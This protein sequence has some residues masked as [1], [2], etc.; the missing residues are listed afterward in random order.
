MIMRLEKKEVQD[1]VSKNLTSMSELTGSSTELRSR[2]LGFAADRSI[3]N[4]HA[5]EAMD[6]YLTEVHGTLLSA[7][8]ACIDCL[9]VRLE[10]YHADISAID[11]S[12]GFLIDTGY[13][14]KIEAGMNAYDVYYKVINIDT[15]SF[16]NTYS[17]YLDHAAPSVD[18]LT[19]GLEQCNKTAK[20]LLE[21]MYALD[22]KYAQVD[23]D[24]ATML[25]AIEQA[26]NGNN[27]LQRDP[28]TGMLNY[29]PGL[30]LESDWHKNLTPTDSMIDL[31]YN[32]FFNED[33]TVDCHYLADILSKEPYQISEYEWSALMKLYL[34]DDLGFDD[35]CTMFSEYLAMNPHEQ[36]ATA[37]ELGQR[38]MAVVVL[39]S[40]ATIWSGAPMTPAAEKK[41]QEWLRRAQLLGFIGTRDVDYLYNISVDD[42]FF[43]NGI[44]YSCGTAH[45]MQTWNEY[46]SNESAAIYLS[47]LSGYF[48]DEARKVDW[49]GYA[50]SI[51]QTAIGF[52]PVVGPLISELS[53]MQKYLGLLNTLID[54]LT[55]GGKYSKEEATKNLMLAIN[56]LGG[57]VAFVRGESG[58]IVTGYS[59]NS[60][61]AIIKLSG[62]S[63]DLGVTQEQALEILAD[64]THPRYDDVFKYVSGTTGKSSTTYETKLGKIYLDNYNALV[65]KYGN[66]YPSLNQSTPINKLPTEV[67]NELIALVK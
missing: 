14:S 55:K 26:C 64:R 53:K 11:E 22:K 66:K 18:A 13:V 34:S 30:A 54:N 47:E 41:L 50:M 2:V 7:W 3:F 19:D 60:S 43:N 40:E 1:L 56:H 31:L 61:E 65:K 27:F 4:G 9:K 25:R 15:N 16:V 32:R 63:K 42:D 17:Q 38:L 10:S 48:I 29:T 44:I 21:A 39:S 57:H 20:N 58:C 23:N 35:V 51:A 12:D 6:A 37:A 36:K 49:V 67:L 59:L 52:V 5:A 8:G 62:L 33:G 46:K 28:K 24:I 45:T